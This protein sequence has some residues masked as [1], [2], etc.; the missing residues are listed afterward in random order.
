MM[1]ELKKIIEEKEIEMESM[2][3]MN[4]KKYRQIR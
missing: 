2:Y 4:E 1:E 3:N